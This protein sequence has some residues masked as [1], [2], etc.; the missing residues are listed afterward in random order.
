LRALQTAGL[1][2][3]VRIPLSAVNEWTGHNPDKT[4][5]PALEDPSWDWATP[6]EWADPNQD[7]VICD[8]ATLYIRVHASKLSAFADAKLRASR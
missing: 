8:P 4:A 6:A 3:R 1:G 7:L 2:G 5:E